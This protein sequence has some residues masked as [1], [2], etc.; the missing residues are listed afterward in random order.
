MSTS[1]FDPWAEAYEAMIDW[2]RRLAH[3]TPFWAWVLERAGR[4]E[5]RRG[6]V[7]DVAAGTGHHAA[8]FA[9]RGCAVEAADLSPYMMQQAGQRWGQR[10]GVRFVTR[11]FDVPA[12]GE[13]DVTL[14][15][16][17]SLALVD[18]ATARRAIALW[19]G[20]TRAGG[21]VVVQVANMWK[22]PEGVPTWQKAKRAT[23]AEGEA[24]IIKGVHRCGD[25]GYVNM[26]VTAL[27]GEVRLRSD[28]VPL[29]LWREAALREA[30]VAGG[31][32][33]VEIYGGYGRGAYDEG[34]SA[35]LI[36]VAGR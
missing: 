20:Q 29:T 5:G 24:L 31:A 23:L 21:V 22:L 36:V 12:E 18:G 1:A 26:L 13:A 3:E 27:S 30:F 33:W 17:N 25:R 7:R 16:G 11:G 35:D 28:C 6:L 10:P 14:C 8:W 32:A 15:V 9:E 34:T 4:P 2:P 19:L